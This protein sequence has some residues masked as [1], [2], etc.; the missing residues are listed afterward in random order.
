[1]TTPADSAP[2]RIRAHVLW[3]T[4]SSQRRD[5]PILAIVALKALDANFCYDRLH[6]VLAITRVASA[7]SGLWIATSSPS[8]REC[9]VSFGGGLRRERV[10]DLKHKGYPRDRNFRNECRPTTSFALDKVATTT[11]DRGTKVLMAKPSGNGKAGRQMLQAEPNLVATQLFEP[12][13]AL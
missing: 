10:T 3:R 9:A 13:T 11:Y 2:S 7:T 8:T 12:R 1:M 5:S 4:K 6:Q